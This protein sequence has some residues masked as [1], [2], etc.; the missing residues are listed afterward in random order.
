MYNLSYFKE[1]DPAE[2]LAFM[3]AHPFVVLCGADASGRPVATQV[4]VLIREENGKICLQGHFMRKT[5]HHL[6]FSVNPKALAIFTG[7]HD[8]VSASWYSNPAQA[9]TWNYISVHA[10][11]TLRFASDEFLVEIL[12]ETTALFEG[13]PH[14]PA[15]FDKLPADY[16]SQLSKAIVAFTIDVDKIENVFKLSQ[17]RDKKSYINIMERLQE[18][19][20][21][22]AE[23]AS[24]MAKRTDTLFPADK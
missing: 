1:N 21:D 10:A 22:A 13:N 16:I 3:R 14:S 12:R 11:G 20:G 8:Y 5:D 6:A 9:S 7:P 15:S 17:N 19:G 2:V 24:E 23:I 18:K 4:P